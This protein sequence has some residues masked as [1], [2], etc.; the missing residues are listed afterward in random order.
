MTL[1][2]FR[3]KTKN[4]PGHLDMMMKQVNNYEFDLS[5]VENVEVKEVTFIGEKEE[6]KDKCLVISDEI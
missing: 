6:P 1:Q 5:I 3:E 2:E 4:L